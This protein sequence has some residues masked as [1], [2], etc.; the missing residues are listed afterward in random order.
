MSLSRKDVLIVALAAV[1]ILS[2]FDA[3]PEIVAGPLGLTDDLAALVL[4]VTTIVR[5]RKASGPPQLPQ[6]LTE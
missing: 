6:D 4:L 1:Y 3:I 5:A 2:P